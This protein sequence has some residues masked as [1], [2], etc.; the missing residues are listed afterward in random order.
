MGTCCSE[1]TSVTHALTDTGPSKTFKLALTPQQALQQPQHTQLS[2]YTA[3]AGLP[4]RSAIIA[5]HCRQRAGNMTD[6]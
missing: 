2:F 4:W 6:I 3:M 1:G 5:M